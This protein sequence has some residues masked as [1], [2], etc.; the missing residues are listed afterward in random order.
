V[1]PAIDLEISNSSK[2]HTLSFTGGYFNNLTI[3]N[4]LTVKDLSYPGAR[5]NYNN[6]LFE[7]FFGYLTK[8]YSVNE[9]DIDFFGIRSSIIPI[10][11]N[12]ICITYGEVNRYELTSNQLYNAYYLLPEAHYNILNLTFYT[13]A[14]IRLLAQRNTESLTTQQK[15]SCF[16]GLVGLKYDNTFKRL[17]IKTTLEYRYYQKEFI[18]STSVGEKINLNIWDYDQKLN[19]WID[20]FDSNRKSQWYFFDIDLNYK[21]F[22]WLYLFCQNEFL[23]CKTQQKTA[24]NKNVNLFYFYYPSTNYYDAGFRFYMQNKIQINISMSN[25]L[26][27]NDIYDG[28]DS[29]LQIGKRF[30]PLEKPY[31]NVFA[32]WNL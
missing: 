4:G 16:A 31:L 28:F 14:G 18:P 8:G 23:F 7:L 22:K 21:I 24:I 29:Y 6:N 27:S 30:Y 3:G 13:E 10:S 1:E 20:F 12:A 32:K 19:N 26:L 25:K 5:L 15:K 9:E 2:T 11:L 17:G